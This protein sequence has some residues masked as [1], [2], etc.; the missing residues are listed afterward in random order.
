MNNICFALYKFLS[1]LIIIDIFFLWF[2]IFSF[3]LK[4]NEWQMRLW[5][6]GKVGYESG[7]CVEMLL[8]YVLCR[9]GGLAVVWGRGKMGKIMKEE[10]DHYSHYLI[11]S[12]IKFFSFVS[13]FH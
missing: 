9:S 2:K 8:C 3:D 10:I 13:Q 4:F 12:I 11:R 6:L 5:K 1:I 7:G